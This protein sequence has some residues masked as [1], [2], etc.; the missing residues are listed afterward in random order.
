MEKPSQSLSGR[1]CVTSTVHSG[2]KTGKRAGE[3]I[4]TLAG[5]GTLAQDFGGRLS[6][7]RANIGCAADPGL[8]LRSRL[9]STLTHFRELLFMDFDECLV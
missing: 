5:P 2:A 8:A 1:A 3:C 6:P 9:K 7:H 4:R